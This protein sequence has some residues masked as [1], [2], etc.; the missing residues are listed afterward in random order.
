MEIVLSTE[1][2]NAKIEQLQAEYA[3]TEQDG[4]AELDKINAEV[5]RLTQKGQRISG[6]TVGKM[7]NLRG[8][9]DELQSMLPKPTNVPNEASPNGVSADGNGENKGTDPLL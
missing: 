3:Q 7:N 1:V 5:E 9:I 4:Q 6:E 2:V 8:R